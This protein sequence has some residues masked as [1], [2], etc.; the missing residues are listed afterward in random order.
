MRL[1]HKKLSDM[2]KSLLIFL[3]PEQRAILLVWFGT[4]CKYGWDEQDFILGFDKVLRYY[5]DHREK[6]M[7]LAKQLLPY[8]QLH[9][10]FDDF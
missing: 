1:T 7:A 8:S 10:S 6:E 4:E 5:P 2:E 3:T 9:L